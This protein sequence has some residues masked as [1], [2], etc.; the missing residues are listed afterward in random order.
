MEQVLRRHAEALPGVSVRYG[1][2]LVAWAEARDGVHARVAEVSREETTE[3]TAR[4]L[5]RIRPRG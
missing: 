3:V 4:Y 5:C 2:R 1:W